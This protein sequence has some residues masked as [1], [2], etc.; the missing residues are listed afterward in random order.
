MLSRKNASRRRRVAQ[1]WLE[2]SSHFLSIFLLITLGQPQH[3]LRHVAKNE[4]LADRRDA[5]DHDFAQEALDVKLL[6][7]TVAAVREDGPLA[8]V[9]SRAR[10]EVF[11]RVGFGAAFLAVVVEPGRLEGEQVGRF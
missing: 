4:L 11:G 10:T 7:V 2:Q 3:A 1:A 8:G 6:G 9:P 5:G